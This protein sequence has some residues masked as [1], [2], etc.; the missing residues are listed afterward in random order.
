MSPVAAHLLGIDNLEPLL[1]L[2]ALVAPALLVC[3]Q[4]D[5]WV[6]GDAVV[7]G[8]AVH[9]APILVIAQVIVAAQM[10]THTRKSHKRT[11][12]LYTKESFSK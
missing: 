12:I 9:A 10:H 11:G 4:G 8:A 1:H 6:L 2:A 7:T 5:V 3:D